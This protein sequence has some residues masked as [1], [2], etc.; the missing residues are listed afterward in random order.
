MVQQANNG[1][2]GS[3]SGAGDVAPVERTDR[4]RERTRRRLLRA[5][6]DLFGEQG[7]DGVGIDAIIARA[8]IS[9]QTFYNHFADR[10]SLIGA[11]RRISRGIFEEAVATA[12]RDVEDPVRRLVRGV[13]VYARMAIGDPL[14]ARFV[15]HAF[16]HDLHAERALD[17]GLEADLAAGLAAGRLE[18]STMAGAVNFVS[19]ATLALVTSLLQRGDQGPAV[20]ICQETLMLLLR[21]FAVGAVAAQRLA[22]QTSHDLLQ[23]C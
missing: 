5:G 23:E 14:H 8:G 6:F 10:D 17:R 16:A 22:A 7:I 12:N 3:D 21:A 9:K 11:L 20:A 13:A 4:R 18:F 15:I 19:G 1:R 2:A